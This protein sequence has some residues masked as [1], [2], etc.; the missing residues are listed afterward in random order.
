[1]LLAVVNSLI[2]ACIYCRR[3]MHNIM[4]AKR[5]LVLGVHC[6]QLLYIS[7]F[8]IVINRTLPNVATFVRLVLKREKLSE[9]AESLRARYEESLNALEQ[10][11]LPPRPISFNGDDDSGYF[12]GNRPRG[13]A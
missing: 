13:M 7:L 8:S 2:G 6:S 11:R 12:S 5:A 3:R 1:M 10:G 4:V 9:E